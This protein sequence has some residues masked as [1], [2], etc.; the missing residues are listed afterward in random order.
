MAKRLDLVGR[1]IGRLTVVRKTKRRSS[2]GSVYWECLCDCGNISLVRTDSLHGKGRLI[3]SCGCLRVD[4]ARE[5]KSLECGKA[6]FNRVVD[7]YVTN[8]AKRGY[9]FE[10][11]KEDIANLVSGPC[12]YCGSPPSNVSSRKNSNGSFKYNG[13]DRV[14]NSIGY[15]KTNCVSCCFKCNRAKD[16]MSVDEFF[17]LVSSIVRKHGLVQE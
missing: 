5:T 3:R 6:S 14:D 12:F 9:S 1:G 13:I 11:S 7:A 10:L 15:N 4:R 2:S 8:A 16:T 17:G